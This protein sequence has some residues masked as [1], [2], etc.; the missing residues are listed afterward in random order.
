MLVKS[1]PLSNITDHVL[2]MADILNI[3]SKSMFMTYL[4]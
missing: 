1:M 2:P 3:T 4:Y